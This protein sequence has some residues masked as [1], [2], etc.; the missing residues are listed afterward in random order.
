MILP[1]DGIEKILKT[2][3]NCYDKKIEFFCNL[4][5]L[6]QLISLNIWTI[7]TGFYVLVKHKYWEYNLNGSKNYIKHTS[8]LKTIWFKN[9]I[10]GSHKI[11]GV[12]ELV[13][14]R[15]R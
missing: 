11:T 15:R 10:N 8:I 7:I 4:R 3:P 12:K 14:D 6:P 1:L 2:S 5:I 9:I 13:K